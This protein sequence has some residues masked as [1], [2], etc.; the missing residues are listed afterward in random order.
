VVSQTTGTLVMPREQDLP[1]SFVAKGAVLANVLGPEQIRVK[2]AVAQEDAGLI[3]SDTRD[4]QVALADLPGESLQARLSGEVPAATNQ[5]PTAALGDRAGGPFVTD[6]A[7]K[8]GLKTL[9]PVFLLD[10][11]LSSMT[12]QRVGG[13]AW[14]RFDH[15]ARPLA[16]QWHRRL[17]QLFLQQFNPQS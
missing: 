12:L 9:E 3:R 16:F 7:D 2:V 14:M 11:Q 10:L 15:G 5:L 6:P 17:Q 1:G 8:D 4:V 13:R